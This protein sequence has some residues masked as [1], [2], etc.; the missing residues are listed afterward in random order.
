[1]LTKCL[2]EL[3][4]GESSLIA[5]SEYFIAYKIGVWRGLTLDLIWRVLNGE[6]KHLIYFSRVSK[7][8][9]VASVLKKQG[10]HST[11]TSYS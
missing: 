1:M 6:Y 8:S 5:C 3:L 4:I 2:V 9:C 7:L 10:W 11:C